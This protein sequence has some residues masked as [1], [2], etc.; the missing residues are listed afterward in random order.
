VKLLPAEQRESLNVYSLHEFCNCKMTIGDTDLHLYFIPEPPTDVGVE[1]ADSLHLQLVWDPVGVGLSRGAAFKAVKPFHRHCWEAI[2]ATSNIY[3]VQSALLDKSS[4][5]LSTRELLPHLYKYIKAYI[6]KFPGSWQI[7][8]SEVSLDRHLA[9]LLQTLVQY[10][11]I[12]SREAEY[13]AKAVSGYNARITNELFHTPPDAASVDSSDMEAWYNLQTL[14]EYQLRQIV[15]EVVFQQ[16]FDSLE[17]LGVDALVHWTGSMPE[18]MTI[19]QRLDYTIGLYSKNFEKMELATQEQTWST[20]IRKYNPG[21]YKSREA[22][23]E[24]LAPALQL[25]RQ[26]QCCASICHMVRSWVDATLQAIQIV[27]GHLPEGKELSSPEVPSLMVFLVLQ[28]GC[29]TIV[30]RARLAKLFMVDEF[31]GD[32]EELQLPA[33]GLYMDLSDQYVLDAENRSIQPAHTLHWIG[34][35]CQVIMEGGELLAAAYSVRSKD[36]RDEGRRHSQEK[37]MMRRPT[38]AL[39]QGQDMD[40]ELRNRSCHSLKRDLE[41]KFGR[42][43]HDGEA[44]MVEE[45]VM[46]GGGEGGASWRSSFDSDTRVMKL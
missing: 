31:G 41:L 2:T 16:T 29:T 35:A 5:E 8:G 38:K 34:D 39:M 9:Y 25:V 42:P 43:L 19:Q 21:E 46:E 24:L 6:H 45:I 33:D 27:N 11:D 40:F 23:N 17:E 36:D 18:P 10:S 3:K 28:G 32:A 12:D 7:D 20:K 37:N 1:P 14:Q 44:Q 26:I 30:I 22:L 4:G 13:T 15:E